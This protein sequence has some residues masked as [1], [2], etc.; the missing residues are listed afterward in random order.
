MAWTSS[1]A[2]PWSPS[3]RRSSSSA[4]TSASAPS[5]P[6]ATGSRR[7][8]DRARTRFWTAY[9]AVYDTVWDSPLT[10]ALAEAAEEVLPVG[11][12]I[13]DLGCGTGLLTRARTAETI[14]V[15]TSAAMLH[16]ALAR[17]RIDRAL[18]RPAERTGLPAGSAGGV[19][20]GNLLH[21]HPEPRA[22]VEEALRLCAP[23][24]TAFLCW[25]L[26]GPD[27]T[28]IHRLDRALGRAALS[29][30]RANA[31]RR[32]VGIGAALTRTTRTPSPEIERAVREAAAGV[33]EVV[34]DATLLGCQ[35]VVVL[36]PVSRTRREET[37]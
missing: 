1:P 20:A 37:P 18:L 35:R 32:L 24:G 16:R 31:L 28:A 36:R 5:R 10:R 2:S 12:T 6:A 4:A 25:P 7:T 8:T 19:I 34:L 26:D 27:T 30:S 11:G 23:E 22:V 13:V 29:A 21:L 3:S 15:D 14:G 9:A 17:R 33:A